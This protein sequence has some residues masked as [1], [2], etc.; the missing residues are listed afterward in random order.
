MIQYITVA[1]V[2]HHLWANCG[3]GRGEAFALLVIVLAIL[4][5]LDA[6]L[7]ILF[8]VLLDV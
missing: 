1:V 2:Q 4:V 7:D 8:L 5:L 3:S 6:C